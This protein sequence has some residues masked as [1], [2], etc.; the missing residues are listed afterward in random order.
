MPL[1]NIKYPDEY[2]G[3]VTAIFKDGK[4]IKCVKNKNTGSDWDEFISSIIFEM[5]KLR[6]DGFSGL[7]QIMDKHFHDAGKP[8]FKRALKK[9]GI[10]ID[11]DAGLKCK[12]YLTVISLVGMLDDLVMVDNTPIKSRKENKK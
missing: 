1:W 7:E 4:F 10:K 9:S 3:I 12:D 8:Y 6:G 2:I 11:S 5:S